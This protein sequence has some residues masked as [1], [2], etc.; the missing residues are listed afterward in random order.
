M[1]I[2]MGIVIASFYFIYLK[3]TQNSR[4][5]FDIFTD[6]LCK[7]SNFTFKNTVFLFFLTFLNWF[8][9]IFKWK[10]LVFSIKRINFQNALQQTLGA[11]TASLFTPNRIGEYGAK[12]IFYTHSYRKRILFLNLVGNAQQML[13]TLI[14]GCIGLFFLISQYNI[15][16][17]YLKLF[18]S[19]IAIIITSSLLLYYFKKKKLSITHYFISKLK[20]YTTSLSRTALTTT[21]LLSFL[22]YCIFSFQF[23]YLLYVFNVNMDYI[24]AMIFIT[25]MYLL[26]SIIPSIFIFDIVVKGGVAIYLFSFANIDSITI[27]SITTLMWLLNFVLPSLIG[28]I[29]VLNFKLPVEHN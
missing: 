6:S 20:T 17:N 12:A 22:R 16:I 29:F 7:N 9:E 21:M 13:V 19:L 4:L 3:L 14:F 25:S 15:K 24:D 11:L 2:K 26:S 28:S 23:F 27:L 18:V 10:T 5:S 1:L 8:F